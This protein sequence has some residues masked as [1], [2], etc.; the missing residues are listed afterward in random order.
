MKV[1]VL[2]EMLKLFPQTYDVSISNEHVEGSLIPDRL[3]VYH[4]DHSVTIITHL[5]DD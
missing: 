4:D 3:K 2:I 5:G 1:D